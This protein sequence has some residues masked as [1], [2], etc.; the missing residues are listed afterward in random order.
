MTVEEI[1]EN[2]C[3]YDLRNPIG[4]GEFKNNPKA[5]GYDEEDFIGLGNFAKEECFCD[6]CFEGR[7][8]LANCILKLLENK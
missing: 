6:N 1:L 5:H 2:L 4:I 7:H 8:V 3:Y